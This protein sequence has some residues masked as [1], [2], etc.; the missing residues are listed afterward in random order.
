MHS[1]ENYLGF[2]PNAELAG[3]GYRVLA[4][5]VANR[6]APLDEKMMDVRDAVDFLKNC[7]G[8]EKVLLLG[9]SAGAS[10]LSAYQRE[11]ENGAESMRGENLIVPCSLQGESIPADGV[12]FLDSNFGN[13]AMTLMSLDPAIRSDERPKER[14]PELDLFNQANG[15]HP[16]G[17]HYT[18]EFKERFFKAQGRRANQLIDQALAS[19]KAVQEGRAPFVDDAPIVIAGGSL[20]VFNNKLFPQDVSLLAHTKGEWPLLHG[21]GSITEEMIWSCRK[22]RVG[23]QNA[24]SLRQG[25]LMTTARTFLCS[26]AVRTTEDYHV[27]TDGIYGIDWD[28]CYCC[29][30]S[31]VPFI[32]VPSLFMGM[33]GSYEYLA[34]ELLYERSASEDKTLLFAA[35]ASHNFTPAYEAEQ[36]SGEFGD[37]V[38]AIFDYVDRWI[39]ERFL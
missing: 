7:P 6:T 22:P 27:S 25:A 17:S 38:K 26:R 37:T 14:I 9:H 21:D 29:T 35:G 10:L 32:H 4:A 5:N 20:V 13:G 1:D 2:V 15:F 33:T 30:P 3:R 11:A 8:I 28:S 23:Q 12:L 36:E 19:L 31:N 39:S 24:A 18:E 34:S 16:D